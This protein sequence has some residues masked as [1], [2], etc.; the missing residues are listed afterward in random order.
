MK[1]Y[2]VYK[3]DLLEQERLRQLILEQDSLELLNDTLPNDSAPQI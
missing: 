3:A 1:D 2:E